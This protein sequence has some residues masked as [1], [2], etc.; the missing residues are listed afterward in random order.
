MVLVVYLGHGIA[1]SGMV[2][3]LIF[4]PDQVLGEVLSSEIEEPQ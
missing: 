2:A 1:S 3:V 4:S